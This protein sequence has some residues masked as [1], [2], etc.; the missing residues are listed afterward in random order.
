[1]NNDIKN[2]NLNIFYFGGSGGFFFLHLLLL[3]KKYYCHLLGDTPHSDFEKWFLLFKNVIY[4]NQ[5]KIKE[6]WKSSETWP[7]N[8]L[9]MSSTI[10]VPKIY[11]TCN[12][13]GQWASLPGRKILLYTDIRTQLRL[14]LYKNAFDFSKHRPNIYGTRLQVTKMALKHKSVINSIDYTQNMPAVWDN[15]ESKIHLQTL[16][17]QPDRILLDNFGLDFNQD[18]KTHIEQWISLH[19][20]KLL[21]K[22][23]FFKNR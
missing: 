19:P 6:E 23:K 18:Q 2:N 17:K 22:C 3:S 11:F 16:I 12:D 5:W 20:Q 4:K 7:T 21:E 1:M 15:A 9:T 13:A 8:T 10:P 14:S